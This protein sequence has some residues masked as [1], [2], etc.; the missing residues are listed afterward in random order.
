MKPGIS[1]PPPQLFV[2]RRAE[3]AML[4]E[5]LDAALAGRGS[6]TVMSGEAGI[7]KSALVEQH[8]RPQSRT[9][10]F[11]DSEGNGLMVREILACPA[12]TARELFTE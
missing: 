3:L 8:H 4:A 9:A 6:L 1:H 11:K 12:P 2:G 10:W 5:A 7:G